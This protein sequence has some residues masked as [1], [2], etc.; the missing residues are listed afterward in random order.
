MTIINFLTESSFK[1]LT[2]IACP[3]LRS[4]STVEKRGHL[5]HSPQLAPSTYSRWLQEH[6]QHQSHKNDLPNFVQICQGNAPVHFLGKLLSFNDRYRNLR[7][8]VIHS[9]RRWGP[10]CVPRVRY[11]LW[12]NDRGCLPSFPEGLRTLR[13]DNTKSMLLHCMFFIAW[14][15]PSAMASSFL[16]TSLSIVAIR[17]GWIAV[18]TASWDNHLVRTAS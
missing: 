6:G 3:L 13:K 15:R 5:V 16:A 7:P 2:N 4:F 14:R 11:D 9:C 1:S 12:L 18:T 17:E 8:I 10:G